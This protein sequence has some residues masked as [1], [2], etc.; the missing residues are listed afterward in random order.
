MNDLRQPQAVKVRV[1]AV[2]L[3]VIEM[4]RLPLTVESE[5]H[6]VRVETARRLE[7]RVGLPRHPLSQAECVNQTIGGHIPAFCQ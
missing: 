2:T 6:I 1:L 3:L 7:M 4:M 5:Q